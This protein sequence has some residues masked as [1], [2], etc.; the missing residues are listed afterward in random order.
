VQASRASLLAVASAAVVLVGSASPASDAE[1]RRP[2]STH[3]RE[4]SVAT[5][6]ITLPPLATAT[7]TASPAQLSPTPM[8]TP[9]AEPSPAPTASAAAPG[10]L[11]G[12][13]P[14]IVIFYL[15]DVDPHDGRLW[16]NPELT[17][18]LYRHFVRSGVEFS[19]A[20]GETPLCCPGRA[21]LLTGLHTEN[22]GVVRNSAVL[23]QPT[24]SIGRAMGSAGYATM[25]IGKHLNL[26]NQLAEWQWADHAAGWTHLDVIRAANGLFTDYTLRTKTGAIRYGDVHST[27]MIGDRA[28][29]RLRVTPRDT[30][31]FAILSP[32]NLHGP[33]TPMPE[34]ANDERCAD[35]PPWRPPSYNEADVADKP[36]FIQ[37]LPLS[38]VTTGWPMDGYCREM[39][40]I[41]WLVGRVVDELE[42]Q[43]RL[44]N[45]LLVFT[46]D[47]GV[48]W[49]AHRLGQRKGMPYVTRIP[50]YM[51]WPAA[52]GTSRRRISEL[53]SNID[54]APTFCAL[55]GC[56]LGPYPTGQRRPDGVSLLPLLEQT[57]TSLGRSG[58]LESSWLRG[59]E[60]HAVRTSPHDPLGQWHYV[61]YLDGF[62]ELYHLT[63]DPWELENRADDP[64][65]ADVRGALA[66]RLAALRAEGRVT[67]R[68]MTARADASLARGDTAA[69][70]VGVRIH[71]SVP[72]EEQTSRAMATTGDAVVH[73][74]LRV[75]N[76]GSVASSFR[77]HASVSGSDLL[78]TRFYA[79]GRDVTTAVSAGTYTLVNVAPGAVATVQISTTVDALA[80][81]GA[82]QTVVVRVRSVVNSSLVDVVRA[83]TRR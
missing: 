36:P 2:L 48:G 40:G 12:E 47:N 65:L 62:R 63:T 57:A 54:L 4:A 71:A 72:I 30:P 46:A 20:I 74:W 77:I 42:R 25:Y 34:F 53:V 58:V 39:L 33:N 60:F 50:L 23:L 82:R 8:P 80:V 21:G 28:V 78:S 10:A 66:R 5:P 29:A 45:T 13:R 3:S 14:N 43:G 52:L 59:R 56:T 79:A 7:P 1:S 22:H 55:G 83:V 44:D 26:N 70:P 61:E 75:R 9:P 11:S 67:D 16:S 81:P 38:P 17:P 15:D 49:G 64:A 41:D 19:Y 18:N 35:M 27:R 73:Q 68:R 32:Y 37:A 69:P 76:T 31:V 51:S 24:E 6:T